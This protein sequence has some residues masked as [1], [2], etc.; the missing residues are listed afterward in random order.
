MEKT[1]QPCLLR[2]QLRKDLEAFGTPRPPPVPGLRPLGGIPEDK[3]EGDL[4]GVFTYTPRECDL[5]PDPPPRLHPS[6]TPQPPSGT[7]AGLKA[8]LR[9]SGAAGVRAFCSWR[10][11]ASYYSMP[12]PSKASP[13]PTALQGRAV[14]PSTPLSAGRIDPNAV[15]L[16]SFPPGPLCSCQEPGSASVSSFI[17]V[18]PASHLTFI[19]SLPAC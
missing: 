9:E 16:F 11:Q 7:P 2:M 12:S 4:A 3:A 6:R 19:A 14:R 15:A 1:D 18:G 5:S 10:N 8:S 17:S 13:N